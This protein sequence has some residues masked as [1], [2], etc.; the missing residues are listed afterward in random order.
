MFVTEYDS[1][2]RFVADHPHFTGDIPDN[3]TTIR[4]PAGFRKAK[5]TDTEWV[6]D[7]P[8][9]Q[10]ELDQRSIDERDERRSAAILEAWPMRKQLEAF[11]EFMDG[12]PEKG[13]AL[14][15]HKAQVKLDIT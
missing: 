7:A 4:C 6:E 14:I 1:N 8:F 2:G 15:A 3:M 13:S 10:S 9:T 5:F 11:A 12:R